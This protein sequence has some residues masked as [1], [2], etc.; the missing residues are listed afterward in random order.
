MAAPVLLIRLEGNVK[1]IK[2]VALFFR[3]GSS[4]KV[5][6]A[7]VIEDGGSYSTLVSWGPR[8]RSLTHGTKAEKTTLSAAEATVHAIDALR[9]K[10]LRGK[11]S[12]KTLQEYHVEVNKK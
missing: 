11:M 1:T 2:S 7:S 9:K 10:K 12:V 5:Y 6:N 8:G 3:E 4:D